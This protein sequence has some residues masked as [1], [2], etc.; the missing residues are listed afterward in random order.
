M[1][2]LVAAGGLALAACACVLP[3][4]GSAAATPTTDTISVS[5]I[6][7]GT[8][9]QFTGSGSPILSVSFDGGSNWQITGISVPSGTT[10]VTCNLTPTNFGGFCSFVTPVQSFVINT[11]ISGTTPT[12]VAGEVAFGDST[13]GTFSALVTQAGVCDWTVSF[14]DPPAYAHV[15]PITYKVVVANVGSAAC[16]AAPLTITSRPHIGSL[17]IDGSPLEIPALAP[18]ESYTGS[19]SVNAQPGEG[20]LDY[21][22][23]DYSATHSIGLDATM[24]QDADGPPSDE[25][26]HA[27]TKLLPEVATFEEKHHAY[28]DT[29]C[30]TEIPATRCGFDLFVVIF[31]AH[32]RGP[33]AV[34]HTA[35]RRPLVVGSV[36]GTVKRGKKGRLHYTLNKTGRKRLRETH[37]LR[38]AL[39]GTRKQG[40]RRT[41]ITGHATLS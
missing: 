35:E 15:L 17:A 39:I 38:V 36:H 21:L 19:F 1:R 29:S 13:T 5:G 11:T 4:S 8:G 23:R 34:G 6:A 30:P 2:Q 22:T 7:S 26:D 10:G 16:E 37:K 9:I 3:F 25:T 32:S 12:A 40:A 33:S 31:F 28:I 18:Q 24:S 41:L 20:F 14:V 27:S